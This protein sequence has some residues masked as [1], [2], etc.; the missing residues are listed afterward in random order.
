[1]S[2]V[3][4][5]YEANHLA[6]VYHVSCFLGFRSAELQYVSSGKWKV[7][8]EIKIE[9]GDKNLV[10]RKFFSR[11]LKCFCDFVRNGNLIKFPYREVVLKTD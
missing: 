10:F 1:M 3:S 6:V 8:K 7:S 11:P 4:T 5:N 2:S 9:I